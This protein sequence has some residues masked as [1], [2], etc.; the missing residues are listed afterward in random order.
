MPLSKVESS[1]ATP[2]AVPYSVGESGSRTTIMTGYA[3]DRSG[4]RSEEA[5][6]REGDADRRRECSSRRRRRIRRIEGKVRSAFGAHFVEVEVDTELGRVRVTKY[7]AVH[8]CGRII[9]PLTAT[10]QIKGGAIDG[11]RHGAARGSALR[12]PHAAS[13]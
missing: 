9:N 3:V 8:D 11:H 6:R 1:G 2:I 7:V 12:P 5:D 10:S 13:R 4:A